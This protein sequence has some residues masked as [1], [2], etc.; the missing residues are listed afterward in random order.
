MVYQ[1]PLL[2]VPDLS[3]LEMTARPVKSICAHGSSSTTPSQLSKY[4]AIMYTFHSNLI[5]VEAV[6][7]SKF[8]PNPASK[9]KP[10]Y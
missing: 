8:A 9:N 6:S 10:N 3:Q 4:V 1:V 5:E 2:L 7:Q